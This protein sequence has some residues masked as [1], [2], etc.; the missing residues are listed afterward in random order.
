MEAMQDGFYTGLDFNDY[1]KQATNKDLS[2]CRSKI[3]NRL[4][5][6]VCGMGEAIAALEGYNGLFFG[7]GDFSQGIGAPGDWNNPKLIETRKRVAEVAV[8]H[9]KFA[10]TSAAITQLDEFIDMGYTFINIGADVIGLHQYCNT[11]LDKFNKSKESNSQK[12]VKTWN[13]WNEPGKCT[14][15]F[16]VFNN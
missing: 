4:R 3:L 10:A 1:L 9:G 6:V 15:L 14:S 11:L 13:Y 16:M 8:K 12:D 5:G 2:Y 7:P